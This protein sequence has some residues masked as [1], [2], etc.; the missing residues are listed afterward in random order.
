MYFEKNDFI[1][2]ATTCNH[3]VTPPCQI[4]VHVTTLRWV[5]SMSC[6]LKMHYQWTVFET[7]TTLIRVQ[8]YPYCEE[9]SAHLAYQRGFVTLL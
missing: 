9:L 3:D 8:T 6:S 4:Q 2:R 5:D 7:A 1:N